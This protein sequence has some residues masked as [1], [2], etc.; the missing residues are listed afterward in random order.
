[1]LHEDRDLLERLRSA[2]LQSAP[3]I[4]W[5][6][7]GRKLLDVYRETVAAQSE[8]VISAACS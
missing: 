3:D 1:M 4:T 8:R 6:A 2:S 7:A 5:T